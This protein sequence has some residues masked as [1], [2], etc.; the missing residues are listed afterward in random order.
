M[1]QNLKGYANNLTI[2]FGYRRR[3]TTSQETLETNNNGGISVFI[4]CGVVFSYYLTN[5]C[6]IKMLVMNTFIKSSSDKIT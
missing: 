4:W 2:D 3:A 5:A 1:H 6:W